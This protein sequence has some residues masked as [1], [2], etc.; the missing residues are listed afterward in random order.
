MATSSGECSPVA[1]KHQSDFHPNATQ[2]LTEFLESQ[3]KKIQIEIAGG[4][5]NHLV[6]QRAFALNT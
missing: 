2:I 3:K 5:K 4:W 6:F 1:I